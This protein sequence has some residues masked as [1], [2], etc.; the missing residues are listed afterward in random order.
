MNTTPLDEIRD[1][2][3][4][5]TEMIEPIGLGPEV[6]QQ[7]GRRRRARGRALVAMSA[8][9][10]LVGAGAVVTQ[11]GGNASHVALSTRSGG[12]ADTP[13]LAFRLVPG[14]V[15]GSS[16]HFTS[17]A[18]LTYE[19]STAPGEA[20]DP[21]NP[22]QALYS[23]TDGEHWSTVDQGKPWIADLAERDGVLYA[24]GTAPG[25]AG[26]LDYRLATSHDGGKGWSNAALP[27]DVSAPDAS[28]SLSSSAG[29]QIARG[30]S[31]T[32]ALLS[33]AFWPDLDAL[34]AAR[35]PHNADAT[36]RQTADGFDIV[37]MSECS[38]ARQL[39]AGANPAVIAAAKRGLKA[40]CENP[41]VIGSISWSDIGLTG[42]ADLSKQQLLVSSDGSHW[43]SVTAP[44]TGYV[45]DLVADGN[46]FVLLAQNKGGA[47]G[48]TVL[49]STDA[50][51]WTATSVP[52]GLDVRAI[53]AGRMI[54]I[55]SAGGVQTST[56]GGATWHTTSV[57]A[58]LPDGAEAATATSSDAGPLGFA[59]I[60]ASK[61]EAHGHEYLLF[62]TDG[63]NW[64]A[65]DLS[66][67]GAPDSA[68][69]MTVTVGA[70][71]VGVDYQLPG[72]SDGGPPKLE[73][74]LATPKR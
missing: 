30:A 43:D 11:R 65:N 16:G 66:D 20:A 62:S 69:P 56:D 44:A 47:N 3:Q 63:V 42:A 34:V 46:G 15:S 18:G 38:S 37:D 22:G 48:S 60:T 58:Q 68:S 26:G 54:G 33:A 45:R 2:L 41:P 29:V 32:V 57:A 51:E 72:S 73:T 23:S 27:F 13:D 61:S 19:L 36:T 21:E 74:L 6:V 7:R 8:A 14:T 1:A 64:S 35:V 4:R 10:C 12:G 53:A 55:D 67:A 40:E 49:H 59:V 39:K 31:E 17:N 24:V 28:V 52:Q 50:R 25:A 9:V 5:E 70:D 71:H